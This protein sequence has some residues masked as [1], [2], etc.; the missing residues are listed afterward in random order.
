MENKKM[1]IEQIPILENLNE[2]VN[3][4]EKQ[5]GNVS[6]IEI[7]K[8]INDEKI[9]IASFST[10]DELKT[11]VNNDVFSQID[12]FEMY[13]TKAIDSAKKISL[14][15]KNRELTLKSY[16]LGITA[17]KESNEFVIPTQTLEQ[18]LS[19]P[20]STYYKFETGRIAK[21]NHENGLYYTL[22]KKNEW[23]LDGR[24]FPWIIG[25]EYDYEEISTTKKIY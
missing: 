9:T 21:Y 11:K 4:F 20:N 7:L 12:F 23:E 13:F 2:F 16:N 17:G 10:V 24:V 3:Y 5:Y 19:D 25:A 14:D 1:K 8:I 22:N 18:A 6:I 15:I